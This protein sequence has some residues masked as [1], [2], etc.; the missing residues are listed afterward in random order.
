MKLVNHYKKFALRSS[1]MIPFFLHLVAVIHF[2]VVEYYF[3]NYM[4]LPTHGHY[5][6]LH[7]H[8]GKYKFLTVW[9]MVSVLIAFIVPF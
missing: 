1:K 8:G 6:I 7:T 4:T 3:T 2:M 5:Q 9:N